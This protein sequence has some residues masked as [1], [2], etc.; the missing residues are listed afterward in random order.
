MS[1]VRTCVFKVMMSDVRKILV[2]LN[3]LIRR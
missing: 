1:V 2:N 3:G